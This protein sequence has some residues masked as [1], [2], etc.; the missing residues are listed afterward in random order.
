MVLADVCISTGLGIGFAVIGLAALTL[1]VR[2][3]RQA[4]R[5]HK[6]LKRP[7]WLKLI[8]VLIGATGLI[9]SFVTCT[10]ELPDVRV[11][12]ADSTLNPA[13]RDRPS[14]ESVCVI[15]R[16]EKPVSLAG[17]E[18]RAAERRINVLPDL[19]LAPS[20]AVRVH[21]GRG[22][23]SSRDLYGEKGSAAWRN[24]GGQITLVDDKGQEIDAAGY[25]E[26]KERD[27]SGACGSRAAALS[28]KITSPKQG[29]VISSATVTITGTVRPGSIVRAKVDH[30]DESESGGKQAKVLSGDGLERFS[31][32]LDLD[33][34]KNSIRLQAERPGSTPVIASL[35]VIRRSTKSS[36][37]GSGTTTSSPACDPNYKGACLDPN[38]VDY[39]CAGGEGN[40]PEYV[41][42]PIEV[43]GEDHFKLDRDGDGT[44]C[45]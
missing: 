44:A 6:R 34:G 38:A 16:G 4:R 39:D 15:N 2:S 1:L 3:I 36:Q 30:D 25:G 7:D 21:P 41:Q 5:E 13:G 14:E 37:T 27:G 43:V 18:L 32:K 42:G 28:L 11:S 8:G 19:T 40:G 20:A 24:Y 17:W 35:G 33:R 22:S 9:A 29:A 31:V 45:E 23:D 26:R 10:E 12:L